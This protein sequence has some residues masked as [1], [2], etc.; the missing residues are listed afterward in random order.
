LISEEG[1]LYF[2]GISARLPM[3][4]G[5]FDEVYGL[6]LVTIEHRL[7]AGEAVHGM[8]T[9]SYQGRYG[10]QARVYTQLEGDAVGVFASMVTPDEASISQ[11]LDIGSPCH[12]ET[13]P[14]LVSL[15]V[16]ADTRPVAVEKLARALASCEIKGV[17]T[18][19]EALRDVVSSGGFLSRG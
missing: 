1:E 8:V 7:A 15:R 16:V 18:N 3:A 12:R 2:V 11:G 13:E 4:V 6:D 17:P 9:G 14:L 19:L 10:M 5:L